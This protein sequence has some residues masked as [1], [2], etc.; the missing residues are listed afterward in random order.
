MNER[1]NEAITNFE[2]EITDIINTPDT[3]TTATAPYPDATFRAR[4]IAVADV[5]DLALGGESEG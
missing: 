4:L 2:A 5:I 3:G 1:I